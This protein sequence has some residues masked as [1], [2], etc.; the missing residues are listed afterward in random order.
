MLQ[1]LHSETKFWNLIS[2]KN[3]FCTVF[4]VEFVQTFLTARVHDH[5]QKRN[6]PFFDNGF[7]NFWV[8]LCYERYKKNQPTIF[9][10]RSTLFSL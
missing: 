1:T 4:N 10:V 2:L 9:Y 5:Q 8:K 6:F 7:Q 3:L